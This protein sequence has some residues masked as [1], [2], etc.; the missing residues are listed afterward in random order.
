MTSN[1]CSQWFKCRAKP[2]NRWIHWCKS[3]VIRQRSSSSCLIKLWLRIN[4]RINKT[5]KIATFFSPRVREKICRTKA[6]PQKL[7]RPSLATSS[8]SWRSWATRTLLFC[9]C[10]SHRFGTNRNKMPLEV[11]LSQPVLIWDKARWLKN[12]LDL[13][14]VST[15]NLPLRP[16]KISKFKSRPRHNRSRQTRRSLASSAAYKSRAKC[17]CKWQVSSPVRS[18]W[19][20]DNSKTKSQLCRDQRLRAILQIK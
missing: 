15:L 7:L 3:C 4:L 5:S 13:N 6:R 16:P 1:L 8:K 12:Q 14:Q 2:T 10:R 19:F 17:S 11:F 9:S 18:I 20:A